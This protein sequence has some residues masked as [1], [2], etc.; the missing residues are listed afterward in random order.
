MYEN[1]EQSLKNPIAFIQKEREIQQECKVVFSE[2]RESGLKIREPFSI[3][4]SSDNFGLMQQ[5]REA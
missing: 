4:P 5:K 3:S 2:I 1:Q